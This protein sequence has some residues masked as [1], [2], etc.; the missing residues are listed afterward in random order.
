MRIISMLSWY[1]EPVSWLAECVSALSKVSDHVVAVDGPYW[2]FPGAVLKP[3]S[4][5]EQA[6][7]IARTAAGL[8]MGCTIHAPRKPWSGPNGG[9][10]AKRDWM[11]QAAMLVAEPGDWLLRVDADEVFTAVPGDVKQRLAETDKH[12]A[13]VMLWER[14]AEDSVNRVVDVGDDYESPLRCLFRATPGIRIEGA[15]FVVS[16]PVD[17]ERR[18]LVGHNTVPAEPLWDVRLEH[19]TRLRSPG[20]KRLKNEY[21]PLINQFEKVEDTPRND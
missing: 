2:G 1:Q 15:H 20:R 8:G 5:P 16:A 18:F 3:A 9:E 17:G 7:V 13:E 10:V 4:G 11:M 19:R 14:E 21:S 12:V 6:D